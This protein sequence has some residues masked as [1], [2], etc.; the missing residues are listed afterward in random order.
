[1]MLSE[2]ERDELYKANKRL[3]RKLWT[4]HMVQRIL[5]VLVVTL[6]IVLLTLVAALS[7]SVTPIP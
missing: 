2:I 4:A 1:M 5:F 6:L 3:E 7:V